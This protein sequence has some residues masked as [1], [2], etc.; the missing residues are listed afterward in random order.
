MKR[1]IV[2]CMALALS[3]CAGDYAGK[4]GYVFSRKAFDLETM[5]ITKVEFPTEE[6]LEKAARKKG[7]TFGSGRNG[8]GFSE[9]TA[10][11]RTCTI[12]YVDPLVT[13]RGDYG[14]HEAM[15]CFYGDW[16]K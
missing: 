1:V 12:Y 13:R 6:A 2:I 15:H 5:T 4:D 7:V 3:A 8:Y 16:H 10:S 11:T 9:I 14:G